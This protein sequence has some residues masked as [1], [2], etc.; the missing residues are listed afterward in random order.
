MKLYRHR[1][2]EGEVDLQNGGTL[3]YAEYG[4]QD[5][6]PIVLFHGTPGSRTGI[7]PPARILSRL[8]VRLIAPDRPGFGLSTR[9][10]GRSVVDIA[11]HIAA[12][13]RHLHLEEAGVHMMGRSGGV[14]FALAC[15]ARLPELL[16]PASVSK[17]SA[18]AGPAPRN[19][20]FIDDFTEGMTAVN[21]ITYTDTD[22]AAV[23]LV[24]EKTYGIHERGDYLFDDILGKVSEPDRRLLRDPNIRLGI[25]LSHI[26]GVRQGSGGW[27]DDVLSFK[28]PWGFDLSEITV[29]VHF[30]HG[31]ED[32][33]MP[34]AHSLGMA[35]ELANHTQVTVEIAQGEGHFGAM[36]AMVGHMSPSVAAR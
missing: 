36:L 22:E 17:V 26:E 16:G 19:M 20:R 32:V 28:K 21:R 8:G 6:R 31:T 9:E 13:L 35:A 33:F 25:I 7:R 12:L 30:W 18:L 10:E 14:P 24:R 29:P 15:A 27:E 4:R 3:A 34:T 11:V 1:G 2:R 5:G 23:A